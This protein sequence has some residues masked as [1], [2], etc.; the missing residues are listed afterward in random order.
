MPFARLNHSH[1]WD[2]IQ[3]TKDVAEALINFGAAV[4]DAR[5]PVKAGRPEVRTKLKLPLVGR[6]GLSDRLAIC[7]L[8]QVRCSDGMVWLGVG[9]RTRSVVGLSAFLSCA[10]L[11][12]ACRNSLW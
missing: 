10:F 8:G 6:A 2:E 3:R 7:A 11:L 9:S 12:D 4:A 5:G 1:K